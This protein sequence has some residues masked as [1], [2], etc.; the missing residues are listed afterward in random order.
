MWWKI[1]YLGNACTKCMYWRKILTE[2]IYKWCCSCKK[3]QQQCAHFIKLINVWLYLR[4]KHNNPYLIIWGFLFLML[5]LLLGFSCSIFYAIS[6]D[7]SSILLAIHCYIFPPLDINV[8]TANS[9]LHSVII[10]CQPA[11]NPGGRVRGRKNAWGKKWKLRKWSCL[12]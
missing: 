12:S 4:R 8:R 3:Q 9:L 1:R 5:L 10:Q 7:V 6:M 2:K 11:M